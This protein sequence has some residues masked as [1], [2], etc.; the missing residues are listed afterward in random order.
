MTKPATATTK[1]ILVKEKAV[2]S[3][4]LENV[5]ANP[6]WVKYKATGA[7][8]DFATA[9]DD[10]GVKV[11]ITYADD[12]TR[13]ID[14][15]ATGVTW[16]D[17]ATANGNAKATYATKESG[18]LA[19]KVYGDI[20]TTVTLNAGI[21]DWTAVAESGKTTKDGTVLLTFTAATNGATT[22]AAVR[23]FLA[24]LEDESTG[25]GITL[26]SFTFKE[27]TVVGDGSTAAKFTAEVAITYTGAPASDTAV[28][29]KI[30]TK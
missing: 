27:I 12:T 21:T 7:S 19:F 30:T 18:N 5:P 1:K 29:L 16:T 13:T 11:E 10:A 6:I 20:S 28:G 25:G 2:K 23:T 14:A 26:D 3:I 17:A 15:D 4:A 9:A 24:T 8:S 22:E